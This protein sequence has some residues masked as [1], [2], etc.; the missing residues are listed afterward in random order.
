MFPP[1]FLRSNYLEMKTKWEAEG[2][3]A[4]EERELGS[5]KYWKEFPVMDGRKVHAWYKKVADYYIRD[6]G[7]GETRARPYNYDWLKP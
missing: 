3:T 5:R 1:K 4:P 2:Y 6:Y 7:Y